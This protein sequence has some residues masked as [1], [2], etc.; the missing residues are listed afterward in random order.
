MFGHGLGTGFPAYVLPTGD[1]DIGPFGLKR[2]KGTIKPGMVLAAE[3][4]LTRPGIGVAAF[5]SNFVVTA[6]GVEKLDGT[7]MLFW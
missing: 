7:P 3:A 1:A 6:T 2:L 4:F 5:E